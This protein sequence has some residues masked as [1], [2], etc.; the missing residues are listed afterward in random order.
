MAKGD[1]K[2]APLFRVVSIDAWS[3][4]EYG[5]SWNNEYPLFEFRSDALDVKRTFLRRLRKFL[6]DGVPTISGLKDYVDLGRGWYYVTDDWEIMELRR[7]SDD[8][9]CYACIRDTPSH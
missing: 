2:F 9:P 6:S 3:E 4:G 7:R 8:C 5:W 1:R